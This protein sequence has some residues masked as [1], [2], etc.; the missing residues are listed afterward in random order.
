MS[1]DSVDL[2][3]ELAA[4]TARLADQ[5]GGGIT[6]TAA[7]AMVEIIGQVRT[8]SCL[9]FAATRTNPRKTV[10]ICNT[11]RN[12]GKGCE[13]TSPLN[14][15]PLVYFFPLIAL[16]SSAATH[17][18]SCMMLRQVT[19]SSSYLGEESNVDGLSGVL[20]SLIAAQVSGKVVGEGADEISSDYFRLS[21]G[22]Y[23]SA[24]VGAVQVKTRV[25]RSQGDQV[26]CRSLAR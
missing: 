11:K 13:W 22:I 20:S 23:D 6:E 7:S 3:L 14:R 9:P 4:D 18:H 19:L 16:H 17:S 5:S 21:T 8:R 2:V 10:E 26:P 15:T 25:S 1:T 12:S 24:A